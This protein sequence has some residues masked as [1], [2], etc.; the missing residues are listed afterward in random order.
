[1]KQLSFREPQHYD[2]LLKKVL[3][4][5]T[6]ELGAGINRPLRILSAASSSG[7]EAYSIAIIISEFIKLNNYNNYQ[8][9]ITGTDISLKVLDTARRGVYEGRRI[10][11]VSKQYSVGLFHEK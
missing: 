2:V 7:E 3:P 8:Y 6:D 10:K 9:F 11:N 4:K 5:L 1:M